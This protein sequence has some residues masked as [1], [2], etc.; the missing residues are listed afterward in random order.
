MADSVEDPVEPH[1]ITMEQVPA[2]ATP[3][4][5]TSHFESQSKDPRSLKRG[6]L[7]RLLI[8]HPTEASRREVLSRLSGM[9]TGRPSSNSIDIDSSPS[10]ENIADIKPAPIDRN[11]H[12]TLDSLVQSLHAELPQPRL[13]PTGGVNLDT[14]EDFLRAGACAVGLGSALVER[15]A[16]AAGNVERIRELAGRYVE[17]VRAARVGDEV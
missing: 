8:I 7:S 11:Q 1:P 17:A 5:L 13:L 14:I 15:Q 10:A 9:P 16:V 2:G 12:H 3:E 4:W 6:G